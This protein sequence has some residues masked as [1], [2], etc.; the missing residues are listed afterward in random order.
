MGSTA[1]SIHRKSFWCDNEE[2]AQI[3]Q[4]SSNWFSRV[5]T[6]LGK[7]VIKEDPPESFNIF[8]LTYHYLYTLF[9]IFLCNKRH[10]CK[11]YIPTKSDISN[12]SMAGLFG[13]TFMLSIHTAIA[14]KID[15]DSLG[16]LPF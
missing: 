8:A 15:T 9:V 13:A 6:A 2:L 1:N 16:S 7:G 4:D 12:S 14:N 10:P 5:N 3:S 11:Q